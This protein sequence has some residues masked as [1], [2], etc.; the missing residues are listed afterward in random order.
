MASKASSGAQPI[1]AGNSVRRGSG[2][3]C[4][5]TSIGPIAM[6]KPGWQLENRRLAIAASGASQALQKSRIVND[7]R[8]IAGNET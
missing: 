1:A 2:V 3:A 6:G 8:Q 5:S 7:F 4:R